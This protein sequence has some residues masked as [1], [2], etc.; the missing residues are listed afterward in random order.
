MQ[1]IPSAFSLQ[2]TNDNTSPE[3]AKQ[4]AAKSQE[5][6]VTTS[7]KEVGQE[8]TPAIKAY[9]VTSQSAENSNNVEPAFLSEVVTADN[10]QC[11][12][13]CTTKSKIC[14]IL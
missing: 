14:I 9:P 8:V 10:S 13:G 3:Q 1:S 11:C 7:L 5:E 6:S 12:G 2:G 4:E